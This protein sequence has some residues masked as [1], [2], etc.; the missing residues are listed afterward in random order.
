VV[1]LISGPDFEKSSIF[2]FDIDGTLLTIPVP[3]D[4]LNKTMSADTSIRNL[5]RDETYDVQ[6]PG[7]MMVKRILKTQFEYVDTINELPLDMTGVM[8]Q[9][10]KVDDLRPLPK[11]N[12]LNS[13][14][15]K[16][17]FFQLI[18]SAKAKIKKYNLS[19]KYYM[20]PECINDIDELYSNKIQWQTTQNGYAEVLPPVHTFITPITT[21]HLLMIELSPGSYHFG[22]DEQSTQMRAEAE[23]DVFDFIRSIRIEFSPEVQAEIDE[24]RG[25][26]E[27]L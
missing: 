20:A 23:A 12:L 6:E 27:A 3:E 11:K 10:L 26:I 18:D 24:V 14:E 2:V 13:E 15:S 1:K 16:K 4:A 17:V 9:I 7:C 8:I 19:E 22:T 21:N 5:H 25:A